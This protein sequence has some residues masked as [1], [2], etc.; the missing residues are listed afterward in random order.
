MIG[1]ATCVGGTTKSDTGTTTTDTEDSPTTSPQPPY[2]VPPTDTWD[3]GETTTTTTTPTD[4]ATPTTPTDT[5]AA[6]DSGLYSSP[7]PGCDLDCPDGQYC[8]S[9]LAP[10]WDSGV[11][12]VDYACIPCGSA[13]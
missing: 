12:G 4:T 1:L 7:A 10:P 8:A 2:G 9:C 13:C 11:Y 5:G 3:T 6:C